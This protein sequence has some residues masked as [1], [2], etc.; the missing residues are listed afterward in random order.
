MGNK[1][2]YYNNDDDLAFYVPFNIISVIL[3]QQKDDDDDERLCNEASY[4]HKLNYASSR[5]QTCNLVTRSQE[6]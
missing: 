5:I 6:R 4:S 3:R 2:D 1:A